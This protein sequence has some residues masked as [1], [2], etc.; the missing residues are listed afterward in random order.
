M[1]RV[2]LALDIGTSAVKGI[3]VGEDGEIVAQAQAS[4]PTYTPQPGWVEH[5]PEDYWTASQQCLVSLGCKIGHSQ[6]VGIGLAGHMSA[7][8]ALDK[9]NQVIRRALTIADGRG[10]QQAQ[11]LQQHHGE[12]IADATGNLPLT[13]FVLPKL[14]W[15]RQHEP[16]HYRATRWVV[17]A[18]DYVRFKLTGEL[19][20]EPTEAG[21]TL[22]LDARSRQWNEVLFDALALPQCFPPLL[23][24]TDI[25]GTLTSEAAQAC[26]LS[27]GIPVI[28]G[29][30]DMAAS[31]LGCGMFDDSRLAIT[32][33]TSGQ[34]TQVVDAPKTELL[35]KFTY[36][37]H[38]LPGKTYVMASIFTGGL[39]LQWLAE[40]LE[41]LTDMSLDEALAR[42]VARA[43]DA[44]VGSQGV[45]F[46]PY[47]VGAGSPSF[48]AAEASFQGLTRAHRG[49]ELS[50]AVLEGVAFNIRH[51]LERLAQYHPLATEVVTAG[52]GFRTPL[53][54]D[55]VRDVIAKPLWQLPQQDVG[56]LGTA[57][58]TGLGVGLFADMQHVAQNWLGTGK[59]SGVASDVAAQYDVAF[60]RYLQLLGSDA[61]SE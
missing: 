39:A 57:L 53:W 18:K 12:A 29:L 24:S 27:K 28:A 19:A 10:G 1:A 60:A 22:L 32:L 47:L 3:A 11:W 21:N 20:S 7:L 34:I 42:V 17:G 13:A 38:A 61:T 59:P 6:V 5:D 51:C 30:A 16:E 56:A 23:E 55:I 50:R 49:A 15:Y 44:P 9:H 41:S 46:I 33:G 58:A 31:V 4:Y 36:H 25:A 2:V 8:V 52:G 48:A 40:V 14:L 54:R 35:G 26:Q 45:T 37:P 43:A